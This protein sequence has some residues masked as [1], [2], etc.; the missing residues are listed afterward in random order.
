MKQ[1]KSLKSK[2][3]TAL[4]WDLGGTFLKKGNGFIISIFLARLLEPA[5][6]GL[7][8]MALVFIGISQ[9]VVDVGFSAAIVQK[10]DI[11]PDTYHSVFFANIASGL[12]LA[13]VFFFGAPWVADFYGEPEVESLVRWLALA[14]LLQSMNQVQMSLLKKSLNFKVLTLRL[15]AGSVVGGVVGVVMAYQGFGAHSLIGQNLVSAAVATISM[16]SV[17]GWR[18]KWHFRWS[19]LKG[20]IGFSGFIF[21]DRLL[22]E[23]S[24][25]MDV[26]V[27]G[28]VFDAAS[29]GFYTRATSLRDQVTYYSSASLSKVFFPVL[30]SIQAQDEKYQLVY[31]R[32]FSVISFSSYLLTGILYVLGQDII[33]LLFG[34]KWLPSVAIFQVIILAASNYPMSSIMVNAFISKGLSKE[35]FN[36]G[37]LRKSLRIIPLVFA[38]YSGLM[39]FVIAYVV[40]SYV[41]TVVNMCFLKRYV[42]LP[43]QRHLSLLLP[44]LVMLAFI[45]TLDMT[46]GFDDIQTR[47]TIAGF[48]ITIYL[49]YHSV[50]KTDGYM[51]LMNIIM[52]K[53]RM[54]KNSSIKS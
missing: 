42:G 38:V 32:A 6:F 12:L 37:L 27:V 17:S 49:G 39:T 40:L 50:F 13:C 34:P 31:F 23:I 22:S 9:V 45:V 20:L 43:I 33:V 30:S 48:F 44:G 7:V 41:L 26:L 25:K 46:L 21:A 54:S 18:P 52:E 5:E 53:F 10:Q 19:D 36:I 29:L 16:W 47:L 2:T 4:M 3:L 1:K 8:G 11:H 28:K 24:K 51:F 15:V 35:N 14:T